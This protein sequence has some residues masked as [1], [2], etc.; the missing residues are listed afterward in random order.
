MD[1]FGPITRKNLEHMRAVR[2]AFA[3]AATTLRFDDRDISELC[4]EL[5]LPDEG[6]FEGLPNQDSSKARYIQ[7]A[8]HI[9][10]ALHLQLNDQA[11]P[12]NPLVDSL[13]EMFGLPK[14][15]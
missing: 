4:S 10:S 5:E 6:K 9:S 15:P 7:A 14:L 13:M 11:R 12:E 3:H 1:I 2:N 8:W